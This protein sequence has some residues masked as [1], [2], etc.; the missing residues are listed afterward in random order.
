[1]LHTKPEEKPL[2]S[3]HGT[4]CYLL[5]SFRATKYNLDKRLVYI[6]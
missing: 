3:K 2:S 4:Y 5:Q 6:Q 1:M